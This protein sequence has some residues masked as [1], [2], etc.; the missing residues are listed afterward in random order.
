MNEKRLRRK[1]YD[2]IYKI[3]HYK[4]SKYLELWYPCPYWST[5]DENGKKYIKRFYRGQKSKYFKRL[6]N[7]RVRKNKK[8]SGRG[9]NYRKLFD[10]WWEMY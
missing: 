3:R 4:M 6:S 10:Y 8:L 7:K 9:N 1:N 2:K 5:F